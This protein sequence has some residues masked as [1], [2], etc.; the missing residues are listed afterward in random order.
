MTKK[1][2]SLREYKREK[3]ANLAQY[4]NNSRTHSPEQVQKVINSINE[5]GFTNPVLVDEN[6]TIIAGHC[7]VEAAKVCGIDEVPCIVLDGLTEDQKAAYVI[8]DNRLA[9]DAGWNYTI[10]LEE[11]QRLEHNGFDISLTGFEPDEIAS[12][13]LEVL[14]AGQ[15]GPDDVPDAPAEPIT[16]LGD[17]W[18]LGEHR[19]MCGD[20][21][22]IDD[23]EKLMDGN[24]A[25]LLVT[26]PPYG[27][28]YT[29]K[30]K[31][32]N[33]IGKPMA[34]PNAIE[35]DSKKP[36]EMNE[37]WLQ[38]L[39]NAYTILDN[40]SSYYIF[41]PQGGDLMMMMA[42]GDAG[43]LLK[44]ML[45]WVK[46]NH[47]LGRCD[48]NY[49]HE[50]ILYGW[51]SNGTHKFYGKGQFKTSVWEIDKPLKNDL[52]PTMKP[53]E[54]IKECILNSSEKNQNI[55]DVFGGSGSTLIACEE[56][57]RKCHMMELSPQ[58]VSVII[59]RWEQYTGKKAIM[60][61]GYGKGNRASA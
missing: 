26:D 61:D 25:D 45:I 5:F 10:L 31:Y 20:S 22:M 43:F 1:T 19:L 13:T 56:T 21:T 48:Y 47:V 29:E 34:C 46:N 52:H 9:L 16:K 60:E 55:I 58:Y 24:K 18:L 42:I 37:F 50:P 39:L 41:S 27:V 17:V 7:R 14:D 44:H 3:I 33:S 57:G 28:S 32:L 40:K 11:V 36:K 12:F 2:N 49:K 59:A 15:C 38:V 54:L 8:A 6:N 23:V 30:N 53:V 51:K 4:T 35:N